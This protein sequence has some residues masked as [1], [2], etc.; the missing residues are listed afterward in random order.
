[1]RQKVKMARSKGQADRVGLS[2]G[3]Q[4]RREQ[5]GARDWTHDANS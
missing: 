2:D 5:V 4:S 1:M 3:L